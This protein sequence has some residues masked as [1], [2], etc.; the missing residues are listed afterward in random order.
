M[1]L[2]G[3]PCSVIPSRFQCPLVIL[4]VCDVRR[5]SDTAAGQSE[6]SSGTV[7]RRDQEGRQRHGRAPERSRSSPHAPPVVSTPEPDQVPSPPRSGIDGRSS[8]TTEL[9][10]GICYS[11]R[12]V[13]DLP[14]LSPGEAGEEGPRRLNHPVS[15]NRPPSTPSYL[16]SHAHCDVSLLTPRICAHCYAGFVFKLGGVNLPLLGMDKSIHLHI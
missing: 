13:R 2:V 8:S 6:S 7:N 3:C 1:T 15:P 10:A 5:S 12:H 4:Q 11:I 16:N 9:K 14:P